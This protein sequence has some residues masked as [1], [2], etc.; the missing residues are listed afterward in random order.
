MAAKELAMDIPVAHLEPTPAEGLMLLWRS[1]QAQARRNPPLRG[2]AEDLASTVICSCWAR[3][4]DRL[5]SPA[6]WHY[7]HK[8]LANT[9]RECWRA[10][11]RCPT[12]RGVDVERL[13]AP[14]EPSW[15]PAARET[16]RYFVASLER[17]LSPPEQEVLALLRAGIESNADIARRRGVSR[18]AVPRLRAAIARK[19]EQLRKMRATG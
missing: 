13:A 3:Q 16:C 10:R 5:G 14:A 17:I 9:M 8:A 15:G 2:D 4:R 1:L 12:A 18:Q 6:G 19:A 11:Q 7:A